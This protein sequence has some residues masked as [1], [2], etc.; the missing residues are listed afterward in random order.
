MAKKRKKKG[1][2][3]LPPFSPKKYVKGKARTLPIGP[4]FATSEELDTGMFQIVVTREQPSGKY[5][6]AIYLID[7]WCLGLKNTDASPNR[8]WE[9][10]EEMVRG[11]GERESSSL[12]EVTYPWVHAMVY[13][14]IE[15]ARS[16]G[17]EPHKDFQLS[18]YVLEPE[19][20]DIDT[21]EIT[22]GKDGKPMFIAGP[23]D[24]SVRIMRIL[25]RT[26]G[27]G[28]YD[29]MAHISGDAFMD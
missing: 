11:M 1:K 10:V 9:E 6:L 15:Y 16:L 18:R 21:P 29:Y 8:E 3:T 24:D 13:G 26:V 14:G 2:P 27:S 19:T 20:A 5:I 17:F 22:F 7:P 23:Y 28:N 12:V 4:C 25:D